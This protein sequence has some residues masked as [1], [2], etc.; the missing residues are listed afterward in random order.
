MDE[1]SGVFDPFAHKPDISDNS[2]KLYMFNL[3][4]LNG[5]KPIK[6]LLFLSKDD[7]VDKINEMKPNTQRTYLISIVYALKRRTEPKLK[8]LYNKYY[9]L[10]M[11]LNKTLKDN[12][13]K[14]DSVKENWIEQKDVIKKQQE[15][16]K[17]LDT[18]ANKRKINND[19]YNQLL[20]LVE[21]S[22]YTLQ[23]PRRNKDY[24][25]MK[26][27]RQ[28]PDDKTYN[29]LDIANWRWVFNNYKTQKKYNQ[30]IIPIPDDLRDIVKLYLKHHPKSKEIKSKTTEVP[31]L[32]KYDGTPIVNS[33]EMTR[34]LNK[35][36]GKKV[37]CSMLRSIYLTNK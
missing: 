4:K 5:G 9:D 18:I 33:P 22:L 12:T 21:L 31:F 27:V 13:E 32:I 16:T 30:Q 35:I 3:T 17:I 6:N 25:Q 29:Y 19:E 28:V 26:I 10:M 8:K 24:L 20:Q 14:T 34:S 2:R 36:L 11:K 37:G 15:L 1:Q 7:I 23:Q